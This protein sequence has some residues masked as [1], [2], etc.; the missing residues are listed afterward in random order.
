MLSQ[1]RSGRVP[2][3]GKIYCAQQMDQGP[4]CWALCYQILLLICA[5]WCHPVTRDRN[6]SHLKDKFVLVEAHSVK[7]WVE[8]TKLLLFMCVK[9]TTTRTTFISAGTIYDKCPCRTWEWLWPLHVKWSPVSVCPIHC[10]SYWSLGAFFIPFVIPLQV[11]RD[12]AW[13]RKRPFHYSFI[14]ICAY[15]GSSTWETR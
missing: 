10:P 2:G 7:R 8:A 13:M 11:Q 1:G 3:F 12:L 4:N 6:R 9:M 15:G 5:V 14:I